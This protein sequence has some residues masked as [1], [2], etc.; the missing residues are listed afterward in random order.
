MAYLAVAVCHDLLSIIQQEAVSTIL[1]SCMQD[2]CSVTFPERAQD[3]AC[4]G[5]EELQCSS[6]SCAACSAAARAALAAS[7]ARL[8]VDSSAS[9]APLGVDGLEFAGLISA[10]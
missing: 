9:S 8:G 4:M 3:L 10:M 7:I 1:M 5:P 2:A 6:V